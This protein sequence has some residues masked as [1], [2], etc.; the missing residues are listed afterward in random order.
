MSSIYLH[1]RT[2]TVTRNILVIGIQP[3]STLSKM[4]ANGSMA[5]FY[6]LDSVGLGSGFQKKG[7]GTEVEIVAVTC[8]VNSPVKLRIV[9]G[10]LVFQLKG[11]CQILLYVWIWQIIQGTFGCRITQSIVKKG[12]ELWVFH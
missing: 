4:S 11:E 2:E 1:G 9:L 10:C 3:R 6:F 7:A 8:K 5:F 12:S